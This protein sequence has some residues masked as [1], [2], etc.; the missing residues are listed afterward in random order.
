MLSW[1]FVSKI[2]S[3]M[4]ST[5]IDILSLSFESSLQYCTY[6]YQILSFSL[7]PASCR[8]SLW[9][10]FVVCFYDKKKNSQFIPLSFSTVKLF[11]ILA[12]SL[13]CKA[14]SLPIDGI[15]QKNSTT[16]NFLHQHILKH[17]HGY[18]Y[19]FYLLFLTRPG[20]GI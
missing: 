9:P 8:T 12:P 18:V 19:S 11:L 4:Y 16:I 13:E 14:L 3:S 6:S 1:P 17:F 7:S 10:W 20:L 15:K 5:W 2:L